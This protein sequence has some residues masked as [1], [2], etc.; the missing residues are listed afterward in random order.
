MRASRVLAYFGAYLGRQAFGGSS[1]FLAPYREWR[2]SGAFAP[3]LVVMP[4]YGRTCCVAIQNFA[5]SNMRPC[6]ADG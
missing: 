5:A 6:H 3:T 2:R 4:M 1:A